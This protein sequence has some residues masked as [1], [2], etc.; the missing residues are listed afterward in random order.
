MNI[1]GGSQVSSKAAALPVKSHQSDCARNPRERRRSALGLQI[2][3]CSTGN[4]L[5]LLEPA[6]LKFSWIISCFLGGRR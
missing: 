3:W 5:L 4:L 1:C 2:G 6:V